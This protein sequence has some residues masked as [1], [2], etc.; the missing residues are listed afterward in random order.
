MEGGCAGWGL[1]HLKRQVV[2][3]RLVPVGSGCSTGAVGTC[4]LCLTGRGGGGGNI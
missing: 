1:E 4:G 2:V 3:K